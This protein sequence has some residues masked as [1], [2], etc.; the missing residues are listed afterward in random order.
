MLGRV[1]HVADSRSFPD[2]RFAAATLRPIRGRPGS[3]LDP[4]RGAAPAVIEA[5]GVENCYTS[6]RKSIGSGDSRGLQIPRK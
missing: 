5:P 1:T 6:G 3:S 2:E 4:S